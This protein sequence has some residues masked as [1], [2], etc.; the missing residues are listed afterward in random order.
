MKNRF[1]PFCFAVLL[2]LT[3]SAAGQSPVLVRGDPPLTEEMVG[4]F[5][6]Y[7]EWAFYVHLTND[8]VNVLRTYS[9]EVWNKQVKSDMDSIVGVVQLQIELS[10]ADPKKLAVLR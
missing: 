3:F 6:E 2:V 4:R 8:Q 9:V 1:S 10:K 5:G 7:F